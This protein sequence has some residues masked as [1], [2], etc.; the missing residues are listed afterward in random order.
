MGLS[1]G[2]LRA[3]VTER[4]GSIVPSLEIDDYC[5]RPRLLFAEGEKTDFAQRDV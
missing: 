5:G 3:A 1:L 2:K 4:S